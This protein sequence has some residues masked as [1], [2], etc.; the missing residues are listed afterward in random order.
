MSAGPPLAAPDIP[1]RERVPLPP[2]AGRLPA[3]VWAFPLILAAVAAL[4]AYAAV[5]ADD[6]FYRSRA[7]IHV[8]GADTAT[9]E[10][11]AAL[12][13]S[14]GVLA[15]T[16]IRMGLPADPETLRGDIRTHASGDLLEIETT[17]ATPLAAQRLAL[18]LADV[19]RETA[20]ETAA[21]RP[22]LTALP[23]LIGAPFLPTGPAGP[24]RALPTALAAAALL[25]L[26]ITLSLGI[27]WRARPVG[28]RLQL[29]RDGGLRTFGAVRRA[30]EPYAAPTLLTR[31]R[32][33]EAG[34]FRAL[35]ARIEVER[36]AR[37]LRT[38][39]LLDVEP[40]I[41]AAG[42]AAN[43]A[44]AFAEAGRLTTLVD[45]DL[46]T[47]SAYRVLGLPRGAS[48]AERLTAPLPE[49]AHPVPVPGSMLRALPSNGPVLPGT[50]DL[51][52]LLASERMSAILADLL[53]S[54]ELVIVSA[55][56]PADPARV[57]ALAARYDGVV[58]VVP[59]ERAGAERLR[60]VQRALEEGHAP[61]LGVVLTHPP[62]VA[63]PAAP[64][65]PAEPPPREAPP[66]W[67]PAV[68]PPAVIDR[69][70]APEASPS[71]PETSA[72]TP[73]PSLPPRRPPDPPPRFD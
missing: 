31:P 27:A 23:S 6:D 33:A 34:A 43:L 67:L 61:L 56:A 11:V 14:D 52:D 1:P 47:P 64:A 44:L 16:A 62:A 7:A 18:V 10:M 36:G 54:A 30:R 17:A 46:R 57:A 40:G 19:L 42:A 38:L 4:A 71:T 63:P 50:L 72:E 9:T 12:A 37:G 35:R 70:P 2:P 53:E 13:T 5:S 65:P 48:L 8:P 69:R 66:A 20:R 3:V 22:D 45:A 28:L 58:L 39:L 60:D 59:A 55:E 32:S 73:D 49:G 15:E 41:G 26:G 51:G 29:E 24:D 68:P 25:A 21:R